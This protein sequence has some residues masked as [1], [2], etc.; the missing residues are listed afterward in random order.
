MAQAKSEKML[1]KSNFHLS[2]RSKSEL[3]M[4]AVCGLCST[5]LVSPESMLVN[6]ERVG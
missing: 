3:E 2:S 4:I 1:K 6:A 5:W